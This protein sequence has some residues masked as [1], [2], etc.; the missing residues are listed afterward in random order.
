MKGSIQL[1]SL[2]TIGISV[3][4]FSETDLTHRVRPI[5]SIPN[6]NKFRSETNE[7]G[8]NILT[9]NEVRVYL[10]LIE[11]R[12]TQ[13]EKA[14]EALIKNVDYSYWKIG[15][16]VS[17]AA[18][19]GYCSGQ[20]VK[21]F[22]GLAIPAT[23]EGGAVVANQAQ[24]WS[25]EAVQKWL[26]NGGLQKLKEV[27]FDV[28]LVG[29][30]AAANQVLAEK[31]HWQYHIPIIGTTFAAYTWSENLMNTPELIEKNGRDIAFLTKEKFRVQNYLNQMK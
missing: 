2:L 24:T 23:V 31:N 15:A 9:V 5:E 19:D 30:S 8:K 27:G 28:G 26:A 6:S 11:D 18:I 29:L 17:K 21:G 3:A 4:A 10:A 7:S 20:L 12:K 1:L 13:L 22:Q 14:N 25:R 16:F